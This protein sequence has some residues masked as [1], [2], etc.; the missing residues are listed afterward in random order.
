M[1]VCE[2]LQLGICIGLSLEGLIPV[3]IYPRMD[4]IILAMNQ[5]VNHL[6]KITAMSLGQY[7]AK[8]IIRTQ[9]GSTKPLNPG[10]QHSQDHTEALRHLLT[11]VTVI[12]LTETDE[13][14][15]AYCEALDSDKSTILIELAEK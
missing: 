2:D 7:K 3:C 13:I 9:V 14:I 5:L 6:D 11:N 10:P 4:F 15:P 8:V 12:K 1:P